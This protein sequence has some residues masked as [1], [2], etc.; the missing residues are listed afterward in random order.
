[1]C[2]NG[3]RCV[4]KYCHDRGLTQKTEF[5]IE[6]GGQIKVM[7]LHLHADGTT[8]SVRVDMGV[9]VLD[10]AQ[11]PSRAQGCPV[12]GHCISVENATYA[13]TLVNM[14]NPH[15]VTFVED[16]DK[17]PVTTHGPLLECHPDFPEKANIEF[18]QV[19]DSTHI[20]MRVWERGTGETLACGTG[21]C[22]CAV[23]CAL[24]GLCGR[25]VEVQLPGGTLHIEWSEQD[26]HVYM[27]GPATF[28]Y[29]GVWLRNS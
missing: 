28:V 27:I 12:M 22:A 17:A 29:D 16:P 24:N 2:G 11:I 1:M 19:V 15:A 13:F 7:Q 20:R 23:A 25:R 9:P 21:A 26:N 6:S 5:T 4:A 14:G 8:E 18:V 3:I 10:G